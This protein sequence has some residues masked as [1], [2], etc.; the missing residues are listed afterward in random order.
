MVHAPQRCEDHGN[1]NGPKVGILLAGRRSCPPSW[2]QAVR[3]RLY[4]GKSENPSLLVRLRPSS[5]NVQGAGN[6][7]ERLGA[8]PRESSE[9][10]R[11]PSLDREEEMVRASWRHEEGGGNDHPHR[12]P[13]R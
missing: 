11:R 8:M 2:R 10:I 12:S 7:Q 1:Y 5:D 9:T 3:S 13:E 4:A 6:Q